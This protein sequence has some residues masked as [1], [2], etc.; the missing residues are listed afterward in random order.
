MSRTKIVCTLGPAT[1]DEIVLRRM[2]HEGMNV[3]RLNFSHGAQDEHKERADT[4]KRIREELKIP[5]ALLMD[6]RGPEVRLGTFENAPVHL[7]EGNTFVLT[8]EQIT[9]TE[10]RASVTYENLHKEME[11]GD[12]I[13]IDDGLIE[14]SVISV[15]GRDINCEILNGGEVGNR[16]GVN[17]PDKSLGLPFI[18]EKD[19][20]DIIFAIKEDFDFIA[21][22]FVRTAADVK[23]LKTVLRE[24]EGEDVKIIAKIENREGVDNI[25]DILRVSD[26][27]MV[28]R[29]DMG[30]EIPFE[31]LPSLQKFI[32]KKCYQ[33]GKPVI[34]ATQMLDSM[35]RNPRPTR[36]EI[37]DVA[38]AIY[39]GTSAIMLSGETSIG[40]YPCQTVRTMTKIAKKT[41]KDINYKHRFH[42]MEMEELKNVTSAISYATCSTAHTLG[43]RAILTITKSG[44]TAR[45]ISRYRPENPI[46][47]T[48]DSPKVWRQLTLSWGVYPIIIGS[49]ESTD[50]VFDESIARAREANLLKSGDLVV[51]TAGVPMGVS[52][53]TNIMKIH[54]VGDVLVE[55]KGLSKGT[56][57][58]PL[59]VYDDPN[60]GIRDFSEGY[61]LVLSRTTDEILPLIKNAAAVITEE[62]ADES[63]A[64][65]VCR[66]LD[67]PVIADAVSATQVLKS[68]TVVT[69]DSEHGLVFSGTRGRE[70]RWS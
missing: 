65:I 31:E 67:I 49:K 36:A 55:G 30:V 64:V 68:G 8:T 13:L 29:G 44:R 6:T 20:E 66:A 7:I 54:I 51:I 62:A 12:R 56:A 16:K 15:N 52:G 70:D 17:F 45:M 39:D 5:I 61:I 24:Q 28:A 57:T 19:H 14:L 3:A 27:L 60:Q 11:K 43:A 32:I 59:C 46:I 35:I 40:K 26:G 37:T 53:S 22:S 10:E 69:V 9:G 25:D 63:Q 23:E 41:E 21:A 47:A 18:N 4:V 33:A 50:E 2:I 1:D 58:G 34:T 38:N 48:T 42:A